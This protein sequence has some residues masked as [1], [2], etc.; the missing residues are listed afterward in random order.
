MIGARAM[1]ESFFHGLSSEPTGKHFKF[2]ILTR[3]QKP[4][5]FRTFRTGYTRIPLHSR[6]KALKEIEKRR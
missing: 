3:F 2:K 4:T 6:N 5:L 1:H